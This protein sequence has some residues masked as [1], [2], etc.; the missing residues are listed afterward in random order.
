MTETPASL[1]ESFDAKDPYVRVSVV[2]LGVAGVALGLRGLSSLPQ[3]PGLNPKYP[4][5]M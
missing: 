2:G 3:A 4:K 1:A 5:P